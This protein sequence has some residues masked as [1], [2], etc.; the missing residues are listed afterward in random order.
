MKT[1]DDP[2][3]PDLFCSK[4]HKGG[5]DVLLSK[6]NVEGDNHI[7]TFRERQFDPTLESRALAEIEWVLDHGRTGG[8]CDL[9][10]A[11]L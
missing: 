3:R 6:Q 11:V 10:G 1:G 5:R 2:A 8:P 4:G 7:G 9:S